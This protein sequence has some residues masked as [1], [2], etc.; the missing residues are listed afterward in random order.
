MPISLAVALGGAVGTL[1]RYSLDRMIERRSDSMFPWS[2]FLINVTGCLVI[3]AVI[4]ALVDRHRSRGGFG[5]V[6]GFVGGYTTFSTFA[7][8]IYDLLDGEH[9]AVGLLYCFTSVTAGIVA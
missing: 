2:T 6:V 3:G 5:L 9:I 7:Q 1:S 8:E 4:A